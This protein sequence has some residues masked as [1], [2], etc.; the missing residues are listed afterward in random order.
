MTIEGWTSDRL[1]GGRLVVRQPAGGYRIAIDPLLLQAA[2]EVGCGAR[3]LDLGAGVGG[4]TLPLAWRRPDLEVVGLERE[5]ALAA[6]LAHNAADNRLDDRIAVVVGDVSCPPFPAAAFEAVIT[7]PPYLAAR[8][9]TSPRTVLGRR[10][11]QEASLPLA[12]WL[13]AAAALVRPGGTLGVVHRADRMDELIAALAGHGGI[14]VMPLWP[15]VGR[16][17]GRVLLRVRIGRRRPCRLLPG[18]VL[19]RDDGHFTAEAE[20]ILRGAAALAWE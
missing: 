11:R 20:R 1:L 9:A 3:V 14:E 19:H 17:A 4:A 12:G 10:A 15:T 5:P 8:R 13:Q 16:A 18:L 7:N 6:A 2:V